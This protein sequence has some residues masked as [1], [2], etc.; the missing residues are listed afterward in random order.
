MAPDSTAEAPQAVLL[1]ALG[2]LVRL[3]DPVGGL[4]AALAARDVRVGAPEAAAAMRAEIAFY[5]AEHHRAGTRAALEALRDDCARVV[6]EHL[7]TGLPHAEVRAALLE[8]IRFVPF[9]EVPAALD[10]LAARGIGLAIVSNWDVSLHD[11]V[12]GLGWTPRFAAVVTSA[13]LGAA[14][15]DPR[16]F[17]AA[18]DALGVA[19]GRAVHAG[20]DLEADVRGARAAGVDGV[21]VAREPGAPAPAGVRVIGGLDELLL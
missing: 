11:V 2:T 3:E 1:D 14:K 12:E 18:L 16:P 6:E 13:E 10:A 4:V 21:L 20:D 15:P 17:V 19:P 7:A 8:A 9:P 5:R